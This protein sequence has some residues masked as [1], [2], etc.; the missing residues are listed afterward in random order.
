LKSGVPAL[1]CG[2]APTGRYGGG[3]ED[4][5]SDPMRMVYLGRRLAAWEAAELLRGPRGSEVA[6]TLGTGRRVRLVRDCRVDTADSVD[7]NIGKAPVATTAP[8]FDRIHRRLRG[9]LEARA[10]A[11]KEARAAASAFNTSG[12]AADVTIFLDQ[13]TLCLMFSE[14]FSLC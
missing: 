8:D 12:E 9:V 6:L 1:F 4:A 11:R 10:V 2:Q 14:G 7:D 13:S 3:S 5:L